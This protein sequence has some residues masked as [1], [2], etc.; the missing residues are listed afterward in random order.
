MPFAGISTPYISKKVDAI[1]VISKKVDM[2]SGIIENLVRPGFLQSPS[3]LVVSTLVLIRTYAKV[4]AVG[5]IHELPLRENK[6][7]GYCLRKS[8]LLLKRY[9]H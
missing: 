6:G 8:C 3:W 1:D 2:S 5:A 4:H 9:E 7:F